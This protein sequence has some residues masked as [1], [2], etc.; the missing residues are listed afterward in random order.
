MESLA[1]GR[2]WCN[3]APYVDGDI[4][5][6][7]I[8]LTGLWVSSGVPTASYVTF[9]ARGVAAVPA[10][11]GVAHSRGRLGVQRIRELVNGAPFTLRQ[12]HRFRGVL[13]DV[14]PEAPIHQVL[15]VM[16]E[17]TNALSDFETTG[18]WRMD[19]FI[20]EQP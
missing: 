12:D 13:F 10:S 8:S 9:P 14:P 5:D 20:R 7:K 6:L 19:V 2:G 18:R 17:M 15:D 4:P 1:Q 3:V 16:C 11:L